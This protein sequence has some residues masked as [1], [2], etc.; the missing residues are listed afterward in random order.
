MF[1]GTLCDVTT[2]DFLTDTSG[3]WCGLQSAPLMR[4]VIDWFADK[5][6]TD[7]VFKEKLGI[8][9]QDTIEVLLNIPRRVDGI[10]LTPQERK[11]LVDEIKG[12]PEYNETLKELFIT[13]PNKKCGDI[14]AYVPR[15]L[16]DD[17][18]V[19]D[20][21]GIGTVGCVLLYKSTKTGKSVVAKYA[22][23]VEGDWTTLEQEAE[24]QMRLAVEHITPPISDLIEISGGITCILTDRVDVTLYQFIKCI[25]H[26][27]FSKVR[28][29]MFATI[30]DGVCD[31]LRTM[32]G[33]TKTT[34]GDL[35]INN[36]ML[37]ST[38]QDTFKPKLIDFGQSIIGVVYP[39]VDVTM[40]LRS[41]KVLKIDPKLY[42]V[43]HTKLNT[44]M[45]RI[46]VDSIVLDSTETDV[47][48]VSIL[49]EKLGNW[50]LSADDFDASRA[51]YEQALS[52]N[53]R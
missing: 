15:V 10:A 38:G 4:S 18:V 33:K 41:M 29:T 39:A 28:V 23:N 17:Y 25:R 16:S 40:F 36:I 52:R 45:R 13:N 32:Y 3:V 42:K 37:V 44:F 21:L 34:H 20:V 30:M 6:I 11:D 2:R 5:P 31:I 12:T 46:V 35:H 48:T 47:D 7:T 14:D 8:I 51:L 1:K 9:D 19:T 50:I 43:A 53:K 22:R 24:I 27:K 26:R 49:E